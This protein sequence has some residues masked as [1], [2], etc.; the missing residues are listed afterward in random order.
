M[1]YHLPIED[2]QCF[3]CTLP[4]CFERHDDCLRQLV[5]NEYKDTN[6]MIKRLKTTSELK[7]FPVGQIPT[8]NF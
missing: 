7:M 6:S 1:Q 8:R 2:L 3:K 5:I 4:D